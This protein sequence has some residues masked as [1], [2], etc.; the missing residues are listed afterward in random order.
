MRI[1]LQI[2]IRIIG[3]PLTMAFSTEYLTANTK[4]ECLQIG[5]ILNQ[6][7][8]F[9]FFSLSTKRS[10]LRSLWCLRLPGSLPLR[11]TVW[12][13]LQPILNQN[14]FKFEEFLK[15]YAVISNSASCSQL[16]M[17]YYSI[18]NTFL[19]ARKTKCNNFYEKKNYP[20]SSFS[21]LNFGSCPI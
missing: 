21:V 17:N 19:E 7:L 18:M 8:F 10:T 5:R 2:M 12:T 11:L 1:V 9:K 20:R 13:I 14:A 3:V 16:T 4:L 6:Y 15:C